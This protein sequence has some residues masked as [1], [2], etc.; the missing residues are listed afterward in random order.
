MEREITKEEIITLLAR[1]KVVEEMIENTTRGD[2]AD[3]LKDLAQDIYL[4]LLERDE[5][6]IVSLFKKGQLNYFIS[7]IITNNYFSI[8]SPYYYKY[9]KFKIKDTVSLDDEKT[10]LDL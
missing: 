6:Q 7:K 9:K 8:T 10:K 4:N 2:C 1:G 3:E 5:E